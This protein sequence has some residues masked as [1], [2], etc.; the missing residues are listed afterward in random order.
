LDEAADEEVDKVLNEITSNMLAGAGS[1]P[2]GTVSSANQ[3]V[4][5]PSH[6]HV[7]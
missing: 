2:V 5:S 7:L 6:F 4:L 3:Q 1:V